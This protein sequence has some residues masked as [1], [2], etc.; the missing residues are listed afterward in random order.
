MKIIIFIVYI[1]LFAHILLCTLFPK[2]VTKAY[3]MS[4]LRLIEFRKK[5]HNNLLLENSSHILTKLSLDEKA[6]IYD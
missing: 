4:C 6:K 5:I 3:V 1:S 2:Q